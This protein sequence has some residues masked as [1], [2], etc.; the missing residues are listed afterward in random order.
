METRTRW[1][2]IGA[3]VLVA[4][5]VVAAVTAIQLTRGTFDWRGQGLVADLGQPDVLVRSARLS[6]LPKDLVQAPL[7]RGV[8]TEDF[9]TYYEDHPTRLSLAG[10]LK[11]LA[12]DHPLTLPDRLISTVLDAPGEIAL[13]R[14]GQGRPAHFALL[15]EHNLATWA[16][17]ELAKVGLPDKQLSVAGEVG[18]LL[19][20]TTVYALRV[21]GRSTWLIATRGARTVVLSSPGLLLE[22]AKAGA[23]D[24]TVPPGTSL[25][26]SQAGEVLAQ[27]LAMGTGGVSPFARAFALDA[28]RRRRQQLVARTD[29]LSFGY[30]HYFPAVAA[31]KTELDGQGAWTLAV[32]A[33]G[34]ALGPWRAGAANLWRRLPRSNALCAAVPVDV[35]RA[36]PL[37]EAAGVAGVPALLD[38]LEPTGAMCWGAGGL[39]AP[40]LALQLRAGTGAKHD[41]VFN[42]VLNQALRQPARTS[43]DDEAGSEPATAEPVKA[44]PL[45]QAAGMQWTRTIAHEFGAVK[46]GGRRV[47]VVGVARLGD[48]LFAST[49]ARNLQQALAVATKTQ[50]ALSDRPMPDSAAVLGIDGPQLAKLLETETWRTLRPSV[51]PTFSRVARELL[52]PRLAAV[53]QIGQVQVGLPLAAVAGSGLQWVDLAV[54]QAA[55]AR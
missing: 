31:L 9:V 29:F 19:Q 46:Q 1:R 37:L 51:A 15:L 53:S 13:W 21:D 38:D 10:T 3:G 18:G 32:Q 42:Q 40:M 55:P 6:Q 54:T 43:S 30:Q 47:D 41:A 34:A 22:G 12:Y 44:Q 49:D 23:V 48:T 52:P 7:L 24:I 5:A 35:S 25:V 14:D 28:V 33:D 4:A 50:P 36:R 16:A 2:W 20:R 45:Q 11:R 17:L 8:L 26:N 39:F 27:A